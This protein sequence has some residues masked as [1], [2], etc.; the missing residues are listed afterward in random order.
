MLQYL[1][2]R[3]S[4][5]D[6]SN[7][8][9][10][11]FL[12][13]TFFTIGNVSAK[14][15]Y[16]EK[17]AVRNEIKSSAFVNLI[18][19]NKKSNSLQ[20]Q[21]KTGK[22]LFKKDDNTF[23][24][25]QVKSSRSEPE[26]ISLAGKWKFRLD[27]EKVG[28]KEEWFKTALPDNIKLPGSCQDQGYGEKVIQPWIGRF[29]PKFKYE[30]PAWY[31]RVINVPVSWKGKHLELFL[32]RCYWETNVW[33]DNIKFGSQNS[34][35]T[36]HV[37]D[38]GS[39]KP[40]RHLLT[41]CVD[42]TYKLPIGRWTSAITYDT[43]GD[44]NGII[45]RIELRAEQL[46]EIKRVQIYP[47]DLIITINN[48]T[49]IIQDANI[50]CSIPRLEYKFQ[51]SKINKGISS[52]KIPFKTIGKLWDDF[53]PV[54]KQLTVKIKSN[55][56]SDKKIIPYA[57][58]KL[59]T[60]G[61]QFTLNG[62][63]IMLR[64]TVDE[65][66]YP[67]T[68]YPPMDKASW[69][70][71]LR[72]C[73]SYGFNFMRFHS[74]CPPEAAFEAGDELG[75]QFQVELPLWTMDTPHFGKDPKRDQFIRD[76]LK[77]ILTVYGN[78]PSFALMAM[79][80]ESSGS[81]DSLVM[82][83]RKL[84]PRHLYRCENGQ[85]PAQGDYV[86]IGERG[87]IGPSTDWDRSEIAGW[88]AGNDNTNRI[89]QVPTLSHEVGQWCMYPDFDEIK[90]F[91]GSLL[92]YNFESYRKSLKAHHM[93]DEDKTFAKASGKFSV[94]LYKEEIEACERTY[95]YGGFEIL[96]ARDHPGQGTAIVGWLDSFWDS[97][98][99]ITPEEFRRFCA[100]IVCLLRMP[101]RVYSKGDLFAAKAEVANYSSDSLNV[102]PSWQIKNTEGDIIASGNLKLSNL[103][104]GKLTAVGDIKVDLNKVKVPD[105]LT[106]MLSAAGTSNSWNIWV[107][108]KKQVT[109]PPNVIITHEFDD[110]T[111]KALAEGKR[112]LL[113][114]SPKEGVITPPRGFYAPDS[115]RYL[116]PVSAGKNAIPGSFMPVFWNARLFNQIGTLGILCDPKNPALLGFPTE[117]HSDWQWADLLGR[118][119]A[120]ESFR[121]AGAPLAMC[122]TLEKK[123]DDKLNRSKAIILNETPAGFRP[124]VQVIDNY[125]RNAKLGVVFETRVGKGK[126]LV[127]AM[128]LETDANKRPEARQMEQSLLNYMAGD[129][130]LPKYELPI[131]LLDKLLLP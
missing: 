20:G 82:L 17:T 124:I 85:T 26:S 7:V 131:K 61:N 30:G 25:K 119:S 43:Q 68:G 87:V 2:N 64:G 97:K 116:P 81:L 56:Y 10:S 41:I 127:C 72:I 5:I 125:D 117:S 33:L 16:M 109:I 50:Q 51:K 115:V 54:I 3:F 62:K 92:P 13:L 84:D 35:S 45:G 71:T 34:L 70:R 129:K 104:E 12:C 128:D 123:A 55:E 27:P 59:S 111:I 15:F 122:D 48:Q 93:L 83:A 95:P 103:E 63:P 52:V 74:W 69:L 65:C 47:D 66:V 40:G 21:K 77:R 67:L 8:I 76:E 11:T 57:V 78:H 130:F 49:G 9:S 110:R 73:K 107:Y 36:P 86:E 94:L 18:K 105:R 112:V 100:P 99:L 31:Q 114:S 1:I 42:N 38:L 46:L 39:I 75:F 53:I 89:S 108:P 88:I 58:R 120:A 90:K 98:G 113:F 80:N 19:N 96:D 28:E 4:R 121:V 102:I 23:S 60:K 91:T 118:F 22:I 32:E 101:K 14:Q 24:G 44:W 106:V 79:G 29:T 37:Y 126:L 6:F